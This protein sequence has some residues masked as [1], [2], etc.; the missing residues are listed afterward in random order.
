MLTSLSRFVVESSQHTLPLFKLL[1][2]EVAFE[3]TQ[4]CE[5][6]LLHLKKAMS[7][8]PVLSRPDK[9]ETFYL[10]LDVASEA[11]SATLIRE[12]PE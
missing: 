10:Y 5:R 6:V 11:V 3:W 4:E 1:R 2:K 12:T 8:P 7:Q 9:K